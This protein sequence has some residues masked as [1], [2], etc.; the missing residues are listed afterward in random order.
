[1]TIIMLPLLVLLSGGV[2]LTLA[3][4]CPDYVQYSAERH[5]PFSSGRHEYPFQRPSEECRTYVVDEIE[6]VIDEDM[7]ST[8]ADPDLY[9]LFVNTWPSTVDSTVK[10]TGFAEDNSE[11]EVSFIRKQMS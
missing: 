6:R 8:I 7:N 1:M 9:R 11:E 4:E 2:A 10:W 5:P 3:Q